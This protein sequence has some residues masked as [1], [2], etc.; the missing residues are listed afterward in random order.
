MF[1]LKKTVCSAPAYQDPLDFP[2]DPDPGQAF[3]KQ[4]ISIQPLIDIIFENLKKKTNTFKYFRY[5]HI[6]HAKYY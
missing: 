5:A 2:S 3:E 1:Q 6:V 4:K